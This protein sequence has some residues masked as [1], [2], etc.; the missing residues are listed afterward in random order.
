M[1][2]VN[3]YHSRCK[4]RDREY[5][6]EGRIFLFSAAFTPKD[7]HQFALFNVKFLLAKNDPFMKATATQALAFMLLCRCLFSEGQDISHNP[8]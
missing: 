4:Y 2:L 6:L 3:F 7:G 5:L 1:I 8:Y